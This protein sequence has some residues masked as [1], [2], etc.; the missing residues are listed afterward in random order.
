MSFE[1]RDMSLAALDMSQHVIF[2]V[3]AIDAIGPGSS[4]IAP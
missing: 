1:L 2:I 3:K 4:C